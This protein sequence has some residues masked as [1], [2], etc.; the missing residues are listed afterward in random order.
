MHAW[1]EERNELLLQLREL[2][3][4]CSML[5]RDNQLRQAE[6]VSPAG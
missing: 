1:S 6:N 4:A 5:K 2:E 3:S